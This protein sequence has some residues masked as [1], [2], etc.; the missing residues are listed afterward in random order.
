MTDDD[1]RALALTLREL[2]GMVVLSGY[3][4]ALY[5]RELYPDWLRVE[6][7]THA[8]GARDRVEVLWLNP[9][10]GAALD[11]ARKSA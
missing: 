6:K 1:H 3:G 11:A 8:D 2:R 4:C 5:D 7:P 9:A 10:C